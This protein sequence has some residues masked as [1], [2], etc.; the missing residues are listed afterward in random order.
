M[1]ALTL[2]QP[3]AHAIAYMGKR[4]ENRGWPVP[5]WMEGRLLAIHAGKRIDEDAW[6]VFE[7][8]GVRIPHR[9]QLARGA[10]V[11]VAQVVSCVR[12]YD[13]LDP[14]QRKWFFGPC[15]WV[16]RDI[17]PIEPIP[18]RGFQ[19]LWK[20]PNQDAFNLTT[21]WKRWTNGK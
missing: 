19:G 4:V 9:D 13:E 12:T 5:H 16:L 7:D 6:R 14:D 18:M 1:R 15:G 21:E 20:V 10:V 3:W 17:V 8:N 2:W 11:A